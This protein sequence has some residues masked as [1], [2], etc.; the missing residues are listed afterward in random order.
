MGYSK[1]MM[2]IIKAVVLRRIRGLSAKERRLTL[3]SVKLDNC[4]S[5]Q[6]DFGTDCDVFARKTIHQFLHALRIHHDDIIFV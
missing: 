3:R 2:A 6:F 5:Y 4:G 1:I